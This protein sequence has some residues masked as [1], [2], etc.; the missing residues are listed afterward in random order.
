M[1]TTEEDWLL[2]AK[3]REVAGFIK[4]LNQKQRNEYDYTFSTTAHEGQLPPPGEWRTWLIMA[5]RGF[6]KTRAGAEWVRALADADPEARIALVA[7]TLGEARSVM[8]E[9]ESGL[10]A[11]CP[12]RGRPAYEPS[13]RKVTFPN[14]AM[15]LLYGANEP[16]SLRGPQHSQAW[17][18]EIGKWSESH[19]RAS[20]AWDNLLLGL[21]LGDDPRV[22]ATTTPRS[23]PLLRRLLG[24][25]GLAVTH[26]RTVD[27]G[28]L[29]ARFRRA[30][31]VEFGRSLLARQELD[32]ELIEEI[33]GA[34]WS[35]A[36]LESGR[37]AVPTADSVRVVIGVD[38]PASAEG[39][40]CGIVVCALSA[41]GIGRV[42]ADCSVR[43]PTPERW[44]RA[45]ANAARVWSADRV[46]AEANQGGEMVRSVVRAADAGGSWALPLKLVHASRG[47]AARAEPVAALYEAGRVRHAGQF[48]EL[49]DQLC[50]LMAGGGYEGPGRSP[51]RADALVWAMTELML[52]R[53]REPRVWRF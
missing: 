52:G 51:D 33:E 45:V 3:P 1:A 53:R 36:L 11:C 43:K 40:A 31:K 38:P 27:N 7:A 39:D 46:V 22:A 44:A 32:G 41:D 15:A 13:L 50:G 49:E 10:L 9:G 26:G 18:D 4:G 23:V 24:G 28:H 30:M 37:E 14:G 21:R 20:K 19:G 47:K 2:E 25:E 12:P 16:E 5:G 48:P 34:L 6:G 29:P 17:C 35:R 42:L 8:V